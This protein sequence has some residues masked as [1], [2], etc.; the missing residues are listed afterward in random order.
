MTILN[1]PVEFLNNIFR[2]LLGKKEA[3]AQ[4]ATLENHPSP[5]SDEEYLSKVEAQ[6]VDLNDLYSFQLMM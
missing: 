2:G 3:T 6:S 5:M 4:V 1:T